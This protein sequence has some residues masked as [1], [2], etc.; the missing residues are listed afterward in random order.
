MICYGQILSM[1]FTLTPLN[2][3]KMLKGNVLTILAMGQLK[4]SL[5][6]MVWSQSSEPIR[7]NLMVTKCIVG[8]ECLIFPQ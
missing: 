4:I 8:M 7:F 3:G 6:R 1:I 2:L 5:G